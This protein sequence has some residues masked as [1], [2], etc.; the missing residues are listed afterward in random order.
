M[1]DE[2]CDAEF[3]LL[4][5]FAR[6][7]S[8]CGIRVGKKRVYLQHAVPELEQQSRRCPAQSGMSNRIREKFVAREGA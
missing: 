2:A 5:Y 3:A 1:Q 8:P 4:I 7:N 6:A